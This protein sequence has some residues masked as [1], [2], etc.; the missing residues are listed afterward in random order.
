MPFM[1][2]LFKLRALLFRAG[3]GA[4]PPIPPPPAEVAAYAKQH[5]LEPTMTLDL[6]GDVKMEFV[7]IP[8]GKFLMGSPETEKDRRNDETQHEVTISKPFYMGRYEVTQ[9]QYEA[10]TGTNPSGFKGVENPV[11]NVS[12]DDAQEFCKRLSGKTGKMVQL[13]TEAQWE[14]ACRGGTKTRFCSGDADGD[15]D[16]VGWYGG[17]FDTTTHP[18]GGKKPNAWGLYD[19][20]GSVF[21]WCQDWYGQ[22][23]A[24]AATGPTGPATGTSRVLRGGTWHLDPRFCRSAFRFNDAPDRRIGVIGF[25]VVLAGPPSLQSPPPKVPATVQP[26]T[27][28]LKPESPPVPPP[29]DVAAYAKE[30]G[31]EPAM[32][33][34]LGNGVKL[35]LVLIPA[36]KFMMGSPETEK[37]RLSD[38]TQH[39][40]TIS[41]PF[42]MGK[43]E[44]TQEQYEAVTG[45]N[46]SLFKDAKNPVENVSWDD[47]QEF[48]KKLSAKTAKTVRLPT[49][50]QWE[51]ACRAGTETRFYSGDA[52]DDLDGVGW[53]F[54]N[55][56]ITTYPVGAKK[57]NAWGLY[58]MHGN[59]WNWC[60]DWYGKYELGAATDPTGPTTGTS[61][62]LRGGSWYGYPWF[63]RSAFRSIDSPVVRGIA[64][65]FRL[66]LAGPP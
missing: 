25:R 34:D 17:N 30:H 53:Y 26:E 63:C 13:P 39:E 48:C 66:M 61:R 6:G 1:R 21:E 64:V 32:S 3:P 35:E 29:A 7:L 24:G 9:E 11:E 45:T 60:A 57:P 19:M 54:S 44:V 22:Y 2:I 4:K 62:V 12:W 20:H 42:Y 31:L 46:P 33:L 49:E 36:G 37:D 28:S 27:K 43:Y 5:G 8:A 50:A 14:Y 58:D 18:V 51:Y 40:V 16:G 38:E 47:A 10:T 52:D 23:E 59:V 41:Q 55:S 56:G 65:G 15:L